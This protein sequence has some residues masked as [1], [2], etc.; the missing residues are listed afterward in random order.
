[1][2]EDYSKAIHFACKAENMS[3]D[4]FTRSLSRQLKAGIFVTMNKFVDAE[5]ILRSAIVE[6]PKNF[7]FYEMLVDAIIN[8]KK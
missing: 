7:Q 6:D 5:K 8:Q 2:A 1:M 4:I 3:P